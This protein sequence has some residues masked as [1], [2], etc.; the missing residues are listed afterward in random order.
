VR[1]IG[2]RSFREG[3]WR[4]V[5]VRGIEGEILY[6][7]SYVRYDEASRLFKAGKSPRAALIP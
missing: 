6:F 5:V 2:I 4:I 3:G 1:I 7:L